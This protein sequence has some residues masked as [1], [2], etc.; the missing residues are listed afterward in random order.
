[1]PKFITL[2]TA[3]AAAAAP[4]TPVQMTAKM[5]LGINMGNTLD[6]PTEGAWAPSAQESFFDAYAARNFT[7]V[8]VPVQWGHHMDATA[9]YAVDAT[10][11]DRV[12]TVVDWSLARGLVTILNTH[13]DEWF[14]SSGIAA[15]PRFVALWTQIAARFASKS[16]L[17][18]FEVYNEP[19][20]AAF[21]VDDL[22]AMNAAILPVIRA[23]NPTRIVL[24]GGLHFMNPT[25]IT[26][27][28]DAMTIPDD[29]QIML[30]VHMY[31]PYKYAGPSPS[32]SA[33]GSDSDVA[34]LESW[35]AALSAWSAAK[36]LPVFLGEFG[37]SV[38]QSAST[39][40][41]VWYAAHA[42]AIAK[43]GFG[44][45]VWDDCGGF[46]VYDRETDTWDNDL[47]VALG[48]VPGEPTPPPAVVN[49]AAVVS[50]AGAAPANAALGTAGAVAAA[51]VV[52]LVGAVVLVVRRRRASEHAAHAA[53]SDESHDKL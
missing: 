28:P 33:W 23:E 45:A 4:L 51:A 37:A 31:D 17:L 41:Y 8:R 6:A 53:P 22:N 5:G 30:E 29:P 24:L 7:N 35:M 16:E 52:A 47:I 19:H 43:H 14:E 44:A 38:A 9:P 1:M 40:R 42:A 18:L 13:H 2:M 15:L 26:A 46:K 10:F 3:A 27:N 48:K 21:S 39:G 25:W 50:P 12:E 49:M 32:V 11:M 20:A 36:G 34:A